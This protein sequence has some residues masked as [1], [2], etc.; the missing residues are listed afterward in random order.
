M[1]WRS[2]CERYPSFVDLGSDNS[3]ST[4]AQDSLDHQVAVL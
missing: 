1:T 2:G 3:Y 4:I